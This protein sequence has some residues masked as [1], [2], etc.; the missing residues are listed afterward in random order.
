MGD[1]VRPASLG[2]DTLEGVI[3]EMVGVGVV[4]EQELIGAAASALETVERLMASEATRLGD[5]VGFHAWMAGAAL[6]EVGVTTAV[7][8]AETDVAAELRYALDRLA[9]L[10][11]DTRTTT[12]VGAAI[13]HTRSALAA[14]A[15]AAA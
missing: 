13:A 2:S 9:L 14:L 8:S 1:L 10:S 7:P 15:T 5:G 12:P 4:T 6:R 11:F 3:S